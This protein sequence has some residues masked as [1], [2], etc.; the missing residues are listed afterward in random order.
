MQYSA[1][2]DS[3]SVIQQLSDGYVETDL[4]GNILKANIAAQKMFQDKVQILYGQNF[5][6]LF[7]SHSEK[8]IKSIFKTLI[9]EGSLTK[10]K[11]IL[12]SG[13]RNVHVEISSNL[14]Y[15]NG[16]PY[17]VFNIIR[18]ISDSFVKQEETKKLAE[19]LQASEKEANLG[20]FEYNE[21][22]GE[23]WWSSQMFHIYGLD[24][25]L[26]I[27][28]DDFVFKFCHPDDL[29]EF[30][31]HIR[32]VKEQKL[33][34]DIIHRVIDE[35][36]NLKWLKKKGEYS[37]NEFGD[38]IFFGTVQDVTDLY[39]VKEQIEK[40]SKLIEIIN[41]AQ[42][43]LI[44]EGSASDILHKT[45]AYLAEQTQTDAVYLYKNDQNENYFLRAHSSAETQEQ[46]NVAPKF[47][48]YQHAG[49]KEWY[50][51]LKKER[52]IDSNEDEINNL[53]R[54]FMGK[55]GIKSMLLIPIHLDNFYYGFLGFD[56]RSLNKNWTDL[57]KNILLSFA[58][59]VGY[60]LQRSDFLKELETNLEIQKNQNKELLKR[61]N[62]IDN[63][64][65]ATFH[66]LRAPIT[67]ML[68]LLNVSQA[69]KESHE[70]VLNN[71]EFMVNK[72]YGIVNE[73]GE[74]AK[75][76]RLPLE[77][78][79]ISFDWMIQ[80]IKEIIDQSEHKK[81]EFNFNILGIHNLI[82]DK[83]RLKIVIRSLLQNAIFYAQVDKKPQVN[84]ELEL[85]QRK[86]CIRIE[87]NGPTLKPK[88]KNE[89]FK[90]FTTYDN[91]S[92]GSGLGLYVANESI[93]KLKGKLN[94]TSRSGRTT[95]TAQIPNLKLEANTEGE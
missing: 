48:N 74:Y 93:Q 57:E 86:G 70:T 39:K 84:I 28:M 47:Y 23:R 2:L 79:E 11:A 92:K 77:P 94:Y 71:M 64:V 12:R 65:Y 58:K 89:I 7:E 30:V 3:E 20:C 73:I 1:G 55:Y 81:T 80:Y 40:N 26:G 95:F 33:D 31:N 59:K 61:N 35:S 91:R 45:C 9:K 25:E 17:K 82:T 67:N 44:L 4:N 66:D 46:I 21:T 10:I 38:T 51:E 83:L 19:R 13:D 85:T 22:T 72:L 69:N 29:S 56:Q 63:F 15:S 42:Q 50:E 14:L 60:F 8:Q 6:K 87:N 32:K 36:G 62:E 43:F 54:S 90:M 5:P 53:E 88:N 37:S 24:P 76:I 18:D 41:Q 49:L 68:G 75:N 78:E 27:P 34:Y 52:V 16:R